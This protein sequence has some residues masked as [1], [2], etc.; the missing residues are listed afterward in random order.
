M[1]AELP[2]KKNNRRDCGIRAFMGVMKNSWNGLVY[3]YKYERSAIFHLISA[4]VLLAGAWMLQLNPMEWLVIVLVLLSILAFELVNT[5]IEAICD[6]VSPEY[7]PLVK[8]A[9]DCGSA[10]T[11]VCSCVA[12]LVTLVMYVPKMIELVENFW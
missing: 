12:V 8:I 4:V 3:F 11:G 6:L 2:N 10:A 7:N 9:K 1:N 5:A